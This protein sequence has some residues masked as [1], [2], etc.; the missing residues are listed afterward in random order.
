M[1]AHNFATVPAYRAY[2]QARNRTPGAIAHWT[3]IPA[4]PTA[5]FKE[6]P[7]RDGT[8]DTERVFRTSGTTRGAER[9]GEH[10]VAD[11]ALYRASLRATFEAYLLPDGVRPS[12][13]SLM[14]PARA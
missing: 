9:R 2:C 4:V 5:A 8:A 12:V 1:F 3:E 14:P 13:L 7:L 11:L 6:L 10:H